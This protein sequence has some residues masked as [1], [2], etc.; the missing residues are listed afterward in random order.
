MKLRTQRVHLMGSSNREIG[1]VT[2]RP[3]ELF[4]KS[5]AKSLSSYHNTAK[6]LLSDTPKID[7]TK[8]PFEGTNQEQ[9]TLRWDPKN[10]QK[11]T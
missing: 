8:N 4:E 6:C 10:K 3:L 5:Y 7:K 2:A 1:S 11:G 9:E